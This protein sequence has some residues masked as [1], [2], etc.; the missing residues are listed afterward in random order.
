MQSTTRIWIGLGA[1]AGASLF[2]DFLCRST[3]R[4]ADPDRLLRS[5]GEAIARLPDA[6]GPWRVASSDP[7][8]DSALAM[9]EC[10][11]Y[12]SRQFVNS[13]T[14]EQVSFIL[15][16]GPAG[17]LVAHSPEVCYASTAFDV[18]GGVR[19]E[20]VRG[21]GP[22]ADTVACVS[23]R[24]KLLAAQN[25]RVYYAFRRYGGHWQ[26][27]KSPRLAL[28]GEPMLYKLQLAMNSPAL[29]ATSASEPDAAHHFLADLL[30]V[31]D[32]ILTND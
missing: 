28:G 6:I 16:V 2:G 14:G 3:A 30:S 31:L 25:Q 18:V 17:P 26:A 29:D 13:T 9:L 7:I 32:S 24:S 19:F 11:A 10:R 12:Q 8:G 23:L 4:S 27:P 15:L 1:L 5:A 22:A 21:T 20:T